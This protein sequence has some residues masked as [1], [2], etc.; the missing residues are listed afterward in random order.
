M[1]ASGQVHLVNGSQVDDQDA[2]NYSDEE[3]QQNAPA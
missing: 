1:T 2:A 3:A